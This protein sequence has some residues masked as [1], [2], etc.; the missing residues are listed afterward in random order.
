MKKI[1]QDDRNYR[2]HPEENKEMINKSLSDYGAGRSILIDS[3]NVII[4]GNGVFGEAEKL[5]IPIKVIESDG[6][7]LIVVK[8]TDLKTSDQKRKL[9]AIAD[10][11]T[12]DMSEF[13]FEMLQDD[14]TDKEFDEFGFN[15]NFSNIE[16][17][18]IDIDNLIKDGIK[19]PKCGFEFKA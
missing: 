19:C 16:N 6:K 3:D 15:L 4:A 2:K 1:K 11:R 17:K 12:S 18:E 14:L 9:L 8:R 10:N 5:N 7:E 13:D